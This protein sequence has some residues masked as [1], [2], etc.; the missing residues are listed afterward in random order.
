MGG[1]EGETVIKKHPVLHRLCGVHVACRLRPRA[2]VRCSAVCRKTFAVMHVLV[3]GSCNWPLCGTAVA[4]TCAAVCVCARECI[5]LYV[6]AEVSPR[7]AEH[8]NWPCSEKKT[9][10]Y[11][12]AFAQISLHL[13]SGVGRRYRRS[14]QIASSSL[15][16][17]LSISFQKTLPSSVLGHGEMDVVIYDSKVVSHSIKARNVFRANIRTRR[18]SSPPIVCLHTQRPLEAA[19]NLSLY[20][21]GSSWQCQTDG[22]AASGASIK[23]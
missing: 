9:I 13:P 17:G 23:G 20:R 15:T 2:T 4:C 19:I 21:T 14:F 11:S 5:C 8:Q 12:L 1:R 10:I 3:V 6:L 22:F 16:A 18:P 7:G